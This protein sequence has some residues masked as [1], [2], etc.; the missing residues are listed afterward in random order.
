MKNIVYVVL[1]AFL[2]NICQ[3]VSAKSIEVIGITQNDYS[4]AGANNEL[5]IKV[6]GNYELQTNEFISDK[7]VL[8]GNIVETVGA[9]KG[10]E[11]FAYIQFT[12]FKLPHEVQMNYITTDFAIAKLSIYKQPDLEKIKSAVGV[13]PE[14][15]MSVYMSFPVKC[16]QDSHFSANGEDNPLPAVQAKGN[17]LNLPQGSYV[18]LTFTDNN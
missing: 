12:K 16:N 7:T 17:T 1:F 15:K 10:R 3:I 6:V 18:I 9:K 8:A 5:I 11:P 13:Q 2:L 4:T 14:N